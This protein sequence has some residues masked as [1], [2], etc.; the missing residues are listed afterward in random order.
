MIHIIIPVK[1]S[2]RLPGKNHFLAPYTFAW[3]AQELLHL[4]EPHSVHIVGPMAERPAAFPPPDI[5]PQYALTPRSMQEDMETITRHILHRDPA[6]LFIQILLTQP[7]REPGLLAR[8]I[9]AA[10]AAD[11]TIPTIT[12]TNRIRTTWRTLD[13]HGTHGDHPATA[14][15]RE[16]LLD[17]AAYAWQTIPALLRIFDKNA[18]K[19]ILERHGVPLCDID[20]PEDIPHALG[21]QWASLN[22]DPLTT[23][24]S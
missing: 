24:N 8:T 3:L 7:L 20:Y 5:W 15:D 2:R 16:L 14:D 18:P 23:R 9:A 19:N 1:E 11:P 13:A 17:G 10:R 21:S 6:P 12:A 22:F 4:R